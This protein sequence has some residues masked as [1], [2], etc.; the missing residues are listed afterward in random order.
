MMLGGNWPHHKG[1]GHLPVQHGRKK[2]NG[3][4]ET[5]AHANDQAGA[6][7][8]AGVV[9]LGDRV[10]SF[11]LLAA[12]PVGSGLVLVG[13]NSHINLVV[14]CKSSSGGIIMNNS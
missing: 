5:E 7:I 11:L 8:A 13:K 1:I 2:G 14:P 3:G 12:V 10:P 4:H 9:D 6:R